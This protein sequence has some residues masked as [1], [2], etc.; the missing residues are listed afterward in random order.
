MK[1][2]IV[3]GWRF[4]PHSYAVVNQWQ[5]LA[6]AR[7]PDLSLKIIDA[8]LY[9]PEWKP[10][11]GLFRPADEEELR[12]LP[13]AKP[14]ERADVTL[15]V[16]ARYDFSPSHSR[17]TAVFGTCECQLLRRVYLRD[18]AIYDQFKRGIA[19]M[20]IAIVTPS[21]WSA[22][23]FY[24]AGFPRDQVHIIPHGVDVDYF[25]PLPDIRS[26]IRSDMGFGDSDFVFLSVGAMTGNKGIDLLLQA[27]AEVYRKHPDARLVLKGMDPLYKSNELLGD[28]MARV[29][30]EDQQRIVERISYFGESFTFREMAMLY[31]GADAYVSPYRAEGFNL[32]VLEAAACGL[33]VICTGGGATDDFVRD[34]F[35]RKI[36]STRVS[37]KSDGEELTLLDPS[38]DHLIALMNSAVEDNSWRRLA[39]EAGPRHVR[40]HFTWDRAT[41]LLANRLFC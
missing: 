24:K 6:L 20:E 30:L 29:P 38:V 15:R 7:R 22:E 26:A 36:E 16:F 32:P 25:R 31:Q 35:A 39:A 3:E 5:L 19:S 17:R 1:S 41:D 2:L 28:A 23:G 13:V 12:T 21:H 14:D 11:E 8:P 27:F 37:S 40:T 4:L 34:P 9:H 10:E 18:S 33:P